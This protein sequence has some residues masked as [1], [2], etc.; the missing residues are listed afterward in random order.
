MP[1]LVYTGYDVV[2]AADS[3]KIIEINS[4]QDVRSM[5]VLGALYLSDYA[6]RFFQ[7]RL[8]AR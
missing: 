7:A 4:H 8:P 6:R 2:I 3:F 5:Q 1:Q